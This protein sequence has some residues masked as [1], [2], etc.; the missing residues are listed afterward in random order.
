MGSWSIFV[1]SPL[2]IN[3]RASDELAESVV[4]HEILPQLVC[5][6][7]F[8]LTPQEEDCDATLSFLS[9]IILVL[10]LLDWQIQLR[11]RSQHVQLYR[12]SGQSGTPWHSRT[13]STRRPAF[14]LK[15]NSRINRHIFF[16]WEELR[17]QNWMR[18]KSLIFFDVC[19]CYTFKVS[20]DK[21]P[22][23]EAA[24][25]VLRA[26]SKHSPQ[27]AQASN[28]PKEVLHVEASPSSY[29][30]LC[31]FLGVNKKH[32][33][34]RTKHISRCE[35]FWNHLDLNLFVWVEIIKTIA[36]KVVKAWAPT[37]TALSKIKL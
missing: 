6:W 21:V 7:K 11:E 32:E 17:T 37:G 26:V 24:A 14:A 25:F 4:T 20:D 15:K 8:F 5:A 29:S 31:Y 30:V 16:F 12:P 36:D 9:F 35:A 22:L 27:L 34:R 13:D 23:F 10:V 2:E 3:G 28:W 18:R 19:V 1:L 33:Q